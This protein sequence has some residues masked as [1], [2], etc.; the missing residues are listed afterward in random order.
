[1]ILSG[2]NR[3][4]IYRYHNYDQHMILSNY[5]SHFKLD[6]GR[7]EL[8]EYADTAISRGLS[9]MGTSPHAPLV[10]DNDWSL[11]EDGLG[12][13]LAQMPALKEAYKDRLEI[14]TGL[15]IDFIPKK[16]GPADEKWHSIGLEYRIGSVHSMED[17]ETG[18]ELSV[19][20]PVD[21]LVTLLEHRFGGDIKALTAEYFKREIEMIEKGGFDILGHCDLVKKR[22][23]NNRF[24]NQ[25]EAWYRKNSLEMLKAAAEADIIVEVN[26]GGISRKATTEVYPSPW[27]LKQC[28][29]LNIPLT[30]SADAHDPRHI[31]FYFKETFELLKSTGYGEVYYLSNGSWHSQPIY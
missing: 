15:E 16:M 31:D 22:N 12:E 1:M 27:M 8:S 29:E 14:I 20:G 3:L 25:D 30:V 17:P 13:Y 10:Y 26:T 19:D 21:D 7:G 24:F 28:L 4:E 2:A 5:H 23:K 18:I 9:I 6:D 11:T